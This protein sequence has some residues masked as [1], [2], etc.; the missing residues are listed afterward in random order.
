MSEAGTLRRALVAIRDRIRAGGPA[1]ADEVIRLA[2]EA[3]A[4]P[5]DVPAEVNYTGL[6]VRGG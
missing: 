3:L 5:R 1:N 6:E 2:D 4:T